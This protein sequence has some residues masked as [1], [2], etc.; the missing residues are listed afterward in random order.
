MSNSVKKWFRSSGREEF[1][2]LVG[3]VLLLLWSVMDLI[4]Q[5]SRVRVVEVLTGIAVVQMYECFYPRF[6]TCMN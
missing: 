3:Q 2:A 1:A 4:P 5:A 6:S